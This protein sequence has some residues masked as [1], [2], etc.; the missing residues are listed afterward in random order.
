MGIKRHNKEMLL[1]RIEPWIHREV[2]AILEDPNPA[3]LVHL[4]TSLFI[5]SLEEI[6]E[7]DY[8]ERLNPFL[9]KWT[10]TFWHELSCIGIS[11]LKTNTS[12]GSLDNTWL[13]GQ[14][15]RH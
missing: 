6:Q 5:T 15:Y 13:L 4:V 10:S 12:S 1:K 14:L 2:Q 9:L 11:K 7:N 8:L 3:I